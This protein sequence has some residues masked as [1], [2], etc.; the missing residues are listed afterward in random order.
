LEMIADARRVIGY[1]GA[2]PSYEGLKAKISG[3]KN[4]MEAFELRSPF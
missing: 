4:F 2:F 1:G 3:A